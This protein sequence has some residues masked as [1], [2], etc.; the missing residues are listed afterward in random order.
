[1]A[2]VNSMYSTSNS[3]IPGCDLDTAETP[4]FIGFD[5]LKE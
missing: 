1:M 2:T 4:K 5:G 3:H